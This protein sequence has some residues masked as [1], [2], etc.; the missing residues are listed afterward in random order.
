MIAGPQKLVAKLVAKQALL[1][2]SEHTQA[3]HLRAQGSNMIP[4]EAT[5]NPA[6]RVRVPH[7]AF[8]GSVRFLFKPLSGTRLNRDA[9]QSTPSAH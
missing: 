4:W 1:T 8:S 7:G 2:Q 9:R 6:G 5:F 3:P